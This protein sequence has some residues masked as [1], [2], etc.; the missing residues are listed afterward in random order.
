MSSPRLLAVPALIW[1]CACVQPPAQGGQEGE[2][3]ADSGAIE[4]TSFSG[5]VTD[6]TTAGLPVD[7]TLLVELR[8][9]AGTIDGWPDAT[10]QPLQALNVPWTGDDTSW[11][12]RLGPE[13]IQDG[14]LIFAFW[15]DGS[16]DPYSG[17]RGRY[18]DEPFDPVDG[19][20]YTGLDITITDDGSR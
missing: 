10:V 4:P 18:S 17:A 6:D 9:P 5:T 13:E 15:D 2:P 19:S 1:A 8:G 12:T 7:A 3:L 11:S 16:G 20:A 14:V